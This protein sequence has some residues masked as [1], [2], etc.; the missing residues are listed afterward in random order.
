ML[1]L[2][3][4]AKGGLGTT[5]LALNLVRGQ[6]GIGLDLYDGQLAVRLDRQAW[7]L[8]RPAFATTGRRRE[9]IEQIVKHRHTLL[10]TPACRLAGEDTWQFVRGVAD[11]ALVVA[12]GGIRPPEDAADVADVI[13][14]ASADHPVARYHER[15]LQDCFP[16]ASVVTMDLAKARHETRE[17][18]RAVAARW[19]GR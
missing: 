18:A 2:L 3:I 4:G 15:R 1:I 8:A 9:A 5:S 17:T 10:W 19:L 16:Q 14:I 7:S 6:K 12:D 13:L 11:R